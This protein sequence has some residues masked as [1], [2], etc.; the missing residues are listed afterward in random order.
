[1]KRQVFVWLAAAVLGISLLS[2][3]SAQKSSLTVEMKNVL[4]SQQW[5]GKDNDNRP[6]GKSGNRQL[7]AFHRW[8]NFA[9]YSRE[10]G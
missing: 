9:G 10:S 5:H 3:V 4:C 8:W 6:E 1:M 7:F 2:Y